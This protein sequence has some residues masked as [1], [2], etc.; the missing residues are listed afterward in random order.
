M[1]LAAILNLATFPMEL[2]VKYALEDE[3]GSW[4]LN[5]MRIIL[6]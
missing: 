6:Y 5:V 4:W 3:Q 2:H 1:L